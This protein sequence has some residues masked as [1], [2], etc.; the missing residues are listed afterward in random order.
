MEIFKPVKQFICN[1]I[2][3]CRLPPLKRDVTKRLRVFDQL[4]GLF[5]VSNVR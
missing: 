5:G 4:T 2:L 3:I 1:S